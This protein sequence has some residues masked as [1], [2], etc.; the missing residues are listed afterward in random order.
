MRWFICLLLIGC[1]KAPEAPTT[2]QGATTT[3]IVYTDEENDMKNATKQYRKDV[4]N[5][6]INSCITHNDAGV[7]HAIRKA[8]END[9]DLEGFVECL[10]ADQLKITCAIIASCYS[11]GY[12]TALKDAK[13]N[14]RD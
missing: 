10:T 13:D 6:W 4:L 9:Y 3:Q 8:V 14:R 5:N 1:G 12:R 11:K 7:G 2:A